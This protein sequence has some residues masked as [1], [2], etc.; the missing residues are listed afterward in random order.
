MKDRVCRLALVIPSRTGL[1]FA[2]MLAFGSQTFV[3]FDEFETVDLF[4]LEEE[5]VAPFFDFDLLQHLTHN[6]FDMLVVDAHTL[7]T[8]D[9]LNLVDEIFRQSCNAL[10]GQNVVRCRVAV[11]DILPL[12]D[13]V[14]ILKME[15]TTFRDQILDR[16]ERFIMR[17]Q[18]D[19][20]LVLVVATER[21]VPSTSAITA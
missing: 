2:G 6:H 18:N 12:L 17:L 20:A 4:P 3:L 9:I 16:L 21:I 1:P 5:A 19:A 11:E 15:R 8:I 13:R 14:T 7:Q 10:N